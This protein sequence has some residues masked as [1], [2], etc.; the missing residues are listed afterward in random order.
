MFIIFGLVFVKR[1]LSMSD[2]ERPSKR[3]KRDHDR[4]AKGGVPQVRPFYR[5]F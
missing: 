4:S 3:V 2:D 5:D 1:A